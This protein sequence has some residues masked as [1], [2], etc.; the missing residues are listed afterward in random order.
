MIDLWNIKLMDAFVFIASFLFGIQVGLGSAVS[1]WIVYGFINPYGQADPILLLFLIS[2]ESFYAIAGA[3]IKRTSVIRELLKSVHLRPVQMSGAPK[4]IAIFE[5]EP[6]TQ[7]VSFHRCIR[8]LRSYLHWIY[9]AILPYGRLSLLFGLIGFQTTFA[10]DIITNFGSWIFRTNSLYQA[11]IVGI[12]TGV[13]FA[14][15]HES[16]NVIFFATVVPLAIGAFN[17][18]EAATQTGFREDVE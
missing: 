12:I 13:P 4:P 5:S 2:G 3:L 16:S 7:G 8:A 18:H 6:G 1:I 15:L 14:A 17:R 9:R 10:Y 11:L